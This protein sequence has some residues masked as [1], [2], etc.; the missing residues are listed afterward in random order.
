MK[1]I[2]HASLRRLI[3]TPPCRTQPVPMQQIFTIFADLQT[4]RSEPQKQQ[5]LLSHGKKCSKK[6]E[7]KRH[8]IE[9]TCAHIIE[10]PEKDDAAAEERARETTNVAPGRAATDPHAR[11]AS[12][13]H[14]SEYIRVT[15]TASVRME[16]SAG[17]GCAWRRRA[18]NQRS[19]W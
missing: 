12:A 7:P 14:G 19:C 1:R 17:N 8:T 2:D 18:W 5:T 4:L 9:P 10:A 15:K 3:N 13:R 11:F 6:N 16:H